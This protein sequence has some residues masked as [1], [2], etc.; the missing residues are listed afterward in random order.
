MQSICHVRL[1]RLELKL[2]PERWRHCRLQHRILGNL[3]LGSDFIRRRDLVVW[4]YL[5]VHGSYL[6]GKQK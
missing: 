1:R 3:H 6:S 5:G 2:A 4:S